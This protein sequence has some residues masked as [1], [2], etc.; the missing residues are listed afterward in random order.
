MSKK[1]IYLLSLLMA[2]SL[3]FASCK[4]NGAGDI[5][6]GI[7]DENKPEHNE[8]G[9][10]G[11][12]LYGS[13]ADIPADKAITKDPVL[14]YS[15]DRGYRNPI[16]VVMGSKK[17]HVL[18]FSELRYAKTTADNDIGVDGATAADIHLIYSSKSGIKDSFTEYG[19]IGTASAQTPTTDPAN[20]H[21]A[22]V[23]FKISDTEIIVVASGGVGISRVST[24]Y[25][26]RTPKSKIE[27]CKVTL[28]E[29][30]EN[31]AASITTEKWTELR[32]NDGSEKS[33]AEAIEGISDWTDAAGVKFAQFGTHSAR[34]FVTSDKR[35]VL[36]VVVANQGTTGSGSTEYMGNL[37]L[38][39]TANTASTPW[40]VKSY[41]TFAKG[42]GAYSKQ[43]ESR[44]IGNSGSKYQYIVVPNGSSEAKLTF[45]EAADSKT[46]NEAPTQMSAFSAYDGS[47]GYL[48]LNWH[49]SS[50]YNPASYNSTG[51][52]E[53]SLL[54]HVKGLEYNPTIYLLDAGTINIASGAKATGW[55]VLDPAGAG[56]GSSIDVLGDGTII[57]V[58]EERA[59]TGVRKFDI[60]YSRYSQS[61]LNSKLLN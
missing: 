14:K 30:N 25:A 51:G 4:K 10:G 19:V 18:V 13:Y 45:G 55:S 61:Y 2:L 56:K 43:K 9:V 58:A 24:P 7:Q 26:K 59:P 48:T 50:E 46:K 15:G 21:A 53:K 33:I 31:S 44:V 27:Y 41:T 57:T 29:G 38:V 37:I 35:M 1:I 47:L 42:N 52:T 22:P 11:N 34:G 49:G 28:I 17:D 3:V 12:G 40:E 60:V 36:P 6:G 23:V 54:M 16:G 32:V 39:S 8:D 5:T 20:S